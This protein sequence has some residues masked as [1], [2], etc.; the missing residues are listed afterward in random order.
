M[1]TAALT[2]L[3]IACTA[4]EAVNGAA[5]G[6][7]AVMT[8][9]AGLPDS[10]F[11]QDGQITKPEV[12]AATLAGL[13]PYPG[14]L[15]WDVGAGC[16]AVAIEWLRSDRRCRAIAIERRAD[17]I[18]LI[19]RNAAA[20]GTPGLAVVAGT[21]PAALAGLPTPDAIFIGGGLHDRS[22]WQA[23]WAAVRPGGR[24]VA[25]AV[26]L[27]SEQ[28]L[29]DLHRAHGGTLTR[30]A[31]ARAEPI[32]AYWGWRPLMPVTQ[33]VVTRPHNDTL[34]EQGR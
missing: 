8:R 27:D 17:R 1:E 26:T 24:L 13:A 33:W 11:A 5:T 18:A 28:V 3:A 14:G 30:L 12:R 7:A 25:N 29:L 31:V 22:L 21:A 19:R 6:A 2:T 34:Q 16:G 32:G 4:T 23:C 9:A 20:L 10:A 15:L